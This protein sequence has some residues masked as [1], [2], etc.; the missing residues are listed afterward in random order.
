MTMTNPLTS[1]QVREIRTRAEKAMLGPWI[2]K[3]YDNE[4]RPT[5]GVRQGPS[6]PSVMVGDEMLPCGFS[7]CNLVEQDMGDI[8][9]GLEAGTATFIAHARTDTP[10]LCATVE[11]LREENVKLR[12]LLAR[13]EEMIYT[14]KA[15]RHCAADGPP[16]N[17]VERILA[18]ISAATKEGGSDE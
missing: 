15:Y 13:C 6:T 8:E 10:A 11:A 17:E 1:K 5:W 9:N 7:I 2:P 14:Q 12:E 18:D 16:P 4:E 3:M